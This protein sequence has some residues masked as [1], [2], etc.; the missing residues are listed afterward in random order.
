MTQISPYL[1]FDGN[2]CEAMNFCKECLGGEL[3]FQTVEASPVAA[4]C[5]EGIKHHIMHSSLTK[6]GFVIMGSD[7]H[8]EKL[9]DGNTVSLCFNCSSEEEI[10]SF[11]SKL[12]EGG[13]VTEPLAQMFWGALFGALTDKFGKQWMFNCNPQ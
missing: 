5:P 1:N 4:Q 9:S 8:R 3:M 7:M 2:C 11:F 10:N 12:S 13:K 6:E